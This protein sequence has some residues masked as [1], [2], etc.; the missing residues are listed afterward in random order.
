MRVVAAVETLEEGGG[1]LLAAHLLGAVL[2]EAVD[3]VVAEHAAGSHE[4]LVEVAGVR[5]FPLCVVEQLVADVDEEVDAV[6]VGEVCVG[7]EVVGEEE[8]GLLGR[9]AVLAE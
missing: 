2:V 4:V 9:G 1:G 5:E 6:R 8:L 7:A 3:A